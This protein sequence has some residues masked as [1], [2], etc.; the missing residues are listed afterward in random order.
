MK[1]IK[2]VQILFLLL[3]LQL[4][5]QDTLTTSSFKRS[6]FFSFD[7]SRTFIR[8]QNTVVNGFKTGIDVGKE[9]RIGLGFYSLAADIVDPIT[10]KREG[11]PD[12]TRLAQL[13]FGWLAGTFE[14]IFLT[15]NK[16][17]FSIPANIG[18]GNSYY[19][20][21]DESKSVKAK[22]GTIVLSEVGASGQYKIV[23]WAGLGFGLGLR[24][25]LVANPQ[26]AQQIS[27]PFYVFK[28]KLFLGEIYRSVF[29]KKQD[30]N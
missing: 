23:K 9:Y 4:F 1:L 30:P 5:S 17:Q 27:S 2:C 21:F 15:K 6:F 13:K 24:N 18:I 19:E 12:T 3:P 20:Y 25:Q 11:L 28:V 8:G 14:F 10:V 22:S 16:W 29:P 26:I 7:N